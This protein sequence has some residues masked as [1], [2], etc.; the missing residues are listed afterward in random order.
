MRDFCP[1]LVL[2]RSELRQGEGGSELPQS[3]IMRGGGFIFLPM[4]PE[5][6][7]KIA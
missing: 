2:R 4:R 6:S 5:N 3:K 7:P 1:A